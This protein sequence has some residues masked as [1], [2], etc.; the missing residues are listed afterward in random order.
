MLLQGCASIVSGT[1][2]TLSVDTPGCGGARCELSND[3]GKYFVPST[4]GTVTISRS[5]NNLQIIC[6]REGA[7]S[8]PLSVASSTK[9]MAFGNILF[10]GVIGAGVDIGTGAAYDYPQLIS[11]AM[12]CGPARAPGES[13]VRLGIEVTRPDAVAG[14]PPPIG[15]KVVRV[16]PASLADQWGLKV[17]DVLLRING[18][19]IRSPDGLAALVAAL[20]A[21]RSVARELELL[22]HREGEAEDSLRRVSLPAS[23]TPM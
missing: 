6:S 18:N 22:L 10:G 1:S 3:K 5:Y 15:V 17:G 11:V 4:P 8:D 20:G 7:T 23:P 12:Q 19:V 9:G 16:L 13:P 14:M 21:D 2:Q